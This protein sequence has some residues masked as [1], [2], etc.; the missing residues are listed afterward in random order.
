LLFCATFL[1][2]ELS[3]GPGLNGLSDGMAVHFVSGVD[4]AENSEK[5]NECFAM[6]NDSFRLASGKALKSLGVP[7]HDF[8]RL[9]IFKHLTAISFRGFH[10]MRSLLTCKGPKSGDRRGLSCQ[11]K[12][13]SSPALARAGFPRARE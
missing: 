8:A 4:E 10:D 11:R 7:N 13:E 12:R 6:R 9:F 1:G 2:P 3:T 5:R